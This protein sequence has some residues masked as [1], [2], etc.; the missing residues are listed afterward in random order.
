VA[1]TYLEAIEMSENL[2]VLV[3]GSPDP[4]FRGLDRG[5]DRYLCVERVSHKCSPKAYKR[6]I[7]TTLRFAAERAERFRLGHAF[8]QGGLFRGNKRSYTTR[9]IT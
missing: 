8:P 6:A 4:V 9:A 5:G 7:S 1:D 2:A 3:Q